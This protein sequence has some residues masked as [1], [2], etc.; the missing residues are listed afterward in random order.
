VT[1]YRLCLDLER[2]WR[3][4]MPSPEQTGL[5]PIQYRD[6]PEVAADAKAWQGCHLALSGDDPALRQEIAAVLLDELRRNP[7]RGRQLR[8]GAWPGYRT[9]SVPLAAA[10]T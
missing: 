6:L 9:K 4:T 10:R 3:V 7:E 1:G 8:D 5:L 2:G